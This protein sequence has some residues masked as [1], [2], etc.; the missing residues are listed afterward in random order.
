MKYFIAAAFVAAA[1]GG[2]YPTFGGDDGV[3]VIDKETV[4]K[5]LDHNG[6]LE[7]TFTRDQ[8]MVSVVRAAS[9]RRGKGHEEAAGLDRGC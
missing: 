3:D 9:I 6:W 4:K 7:F 8:M 1:L 5:A 2:L